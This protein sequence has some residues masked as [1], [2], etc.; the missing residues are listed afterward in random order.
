MPAVPRVHLA[1]VDS[2]NLEA[3]RRA[4]AGQTWPLWITAGRQLHG[5]GRQGREWISE[6]GNLYATLLLNPACAPEQAAGLSFVAATS[7]ADAV[8][9]LAPGSKPRLKWPNDVLLESRKIAG[10]LIETEWREGR[11]IAAVGCGLNLAH[12]PAQVRYPAASLAELG[13]AASPDEAFIALAKAFAQR[14]AEWDEARGF[15]T[16]REAWL[17]RAHAMGEA[18][19]LDLGSESITGTFTGMAPD[20]AM[21]LQ[22]ADKSSRIIHAGEVRATIR[23]GAA[24]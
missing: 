5:R 9:A 19:S 11:L 1:E 7:L 13:H 14:L 10:I 24:T 15:A 18:V 20:G 17:S 3:M 12:S 2:T 23:P 4:A 22:L 21:I 16:I 6:T 8:E